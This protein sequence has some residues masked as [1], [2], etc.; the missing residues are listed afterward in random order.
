MNKLFPPRSF[1][2]KVARISPMYS[3]RVPTEE[4]DMKN[5]LLLAGVFLALITT[6]VNTAQAGANVGAC[7]APIIVSN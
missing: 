5:L 4:G 3:G 2:D 6:V 7:R 1:C